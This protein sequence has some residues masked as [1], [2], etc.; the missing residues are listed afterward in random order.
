[1]KRGTTHG[2]VGH[3]AE[4]LVR[5]VRLLLMLSSREVDGDEFIGNVALSG[6]LGD[7]ARASGYVIPMKLECHDESGGRSVRMRVCC[8]KAGLHFLGPIATV[9][10]SACSVLHVQRPPFI[11]FSRSPYFF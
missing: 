11:R 8:A 9:F 3:L 6:Y 1:M 4:R 10:I 2:D 5:D 7:A